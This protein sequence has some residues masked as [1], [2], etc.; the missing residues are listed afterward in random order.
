MNWEFLLYVLKRMG[1]GERWIGWIRQCISSA[2]FAVLV[3]GSPTEFFSASR[4]IRQGDPLSPLFFLLVMETFTRMIEAAS[5]AGLIFGF[6]V[7]SA[8][9]AMS[10]SHLLFADDTIIF[11]DNDCEQMVNLRCVL[12]W[13]EAV[14][15]LRVNL[16][17]SSLLPVGEVDNIQ[18]LAGVLGCSIDSFPSTYLGLPLGARFK[19]KAIWDPIIGRFEKRLSGWKARYL[20]K[21]GRL[22]LIKSVLSSLPTYFLSLFPIPSSVANKLEA[23]QRSFLWGVLL[24]V[25][26]NITL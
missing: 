6:S 10:I 7:G 3:N 12:T 2:S 21:G 16:A 14:S 26:T 18:L 8:N 13:F 20:S 25:T 9:A 22:T 5:T 15:G 1:F 4:G 24:G 23:I 17:K 19:E 11:C